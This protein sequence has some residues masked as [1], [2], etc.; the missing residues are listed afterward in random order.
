M[1][2]IT[3]SQITKHTTG[4]GFK[5]IFDERSEAERCKDMIFWILK[6]ERGYKVNIR[7]SRSEKK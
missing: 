1:K 7:Y 6:D 5:I 4:Y 2:N 3:I